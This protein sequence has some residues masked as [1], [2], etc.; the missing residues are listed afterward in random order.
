MYIN[1]ATFCFKKKK[2]FLYYFHFYWVH[3]IILPTMCYPSTSDSGSLTTCNVRVGNSKHLLKAVLISGL[4]LMLNQ[5]T[6]YIVRETPC[7]DEPTDIYS[8][9]NIFPLLTELFNL[10]FLSFVKDQPRAK[11]RVN[12]GLQ[13]IR[14]AQTNKCKCCYVCAWWKIHKM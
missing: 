1:Q 6:M 5:K 8:Q 2:K 10:F 9:L 13:F 11:R 14:W 7:N 3:T 4:G 12:I